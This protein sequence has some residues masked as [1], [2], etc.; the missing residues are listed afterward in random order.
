VGRPSYYR[1]GINRYQIR[2][3]VAAPDENS[4]VIVVE[5]ITD[6]SSGRHIRYMVETLTLR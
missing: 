1:D 4:L 2:Q 5:R 3:V 6:S